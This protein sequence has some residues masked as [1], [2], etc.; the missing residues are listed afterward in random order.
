MKEFPDRW[1]KSRHP[2]PVFRKRTTVKVRM[3]AGW[4]K[5]IVQDST[6]DRCTVWLS[7][8]QKTTVCHDARNIFQSS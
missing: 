8:E 7:R 2:L 4:S 5:G 6:R 3:G 1:K